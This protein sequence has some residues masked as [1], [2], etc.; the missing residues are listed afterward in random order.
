[1]MIPDSKNRFQKSLEDLL[2]FLGEHADEATVVGSE[3]L[4]QAKS[5]LSANDMPFE[6]HV[7]GA[8]AEGGEEFAEGEI[9]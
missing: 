5:L 9:F 2:D 7:E 8:A 6:P 4:D 1:M 3:L